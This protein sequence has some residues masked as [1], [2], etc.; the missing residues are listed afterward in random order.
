M[1]SA[2]RRHFGPNSRP[3]CCVMESL[4][5]AEAE[6]EADGEIRAA[7][8]ATPTRQTAPLTRSSRQEMSQNPPNGASSA[9]GDGRSSRVDLQ[10]SNVMSASSEDAVQKPG[11]T[12]P[13]FGVKHYLHNFYGLPQYD[14]TT[15]VWQQIHSVSTAILFLILLFV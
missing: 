8:E 4:A 1:T 10:V 2:G 3:G 15:K 14:E 7:A 13:F 6:T 12:A 11:C 5:E 9:R